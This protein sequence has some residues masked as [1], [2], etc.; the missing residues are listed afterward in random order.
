MLDEPDMVKIK[1]ALISAME[2]LAMKKIEQ[3]DRDFVSAQLYLALKII[4][5]IEGD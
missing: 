5:A 3:R 4:K 2:L 1:A